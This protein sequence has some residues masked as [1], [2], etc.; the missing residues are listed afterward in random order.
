MDSHVG[1][2]PDEV[3]PGQFLVR[4]ILLSSV[5]VIRSMVHNNSVTTEDNQ[6]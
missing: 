1:F 2:V 6:P 3:A 4:V 5:G